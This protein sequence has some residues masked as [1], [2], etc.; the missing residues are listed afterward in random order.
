[1]ER[2]LEQPMQRDVRPGVKHQTKEIDMDDRDQDYGRRRGIIVAGH[3]EKEP[4]HGAHGGT[5]E[6]STYGSGVPRHG[7]QYGAGERF[8]QG[9]R[10]GGSTGSGD[11]RAAYPYQRSFRGSE[12][13]SGQGYYGD[14]RAEGEHRGKGP[15]GYQRADERIEEDVN[16]RLSEDPY[17]D[18]SG[19]EVSVTSSEVTL[20]GQVARRA[21]KRR[22]EDCAESVSGVTNVQNNLRI[23]AS[24]DDDRSATFT[25]A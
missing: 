13:R 24:S 25:Q 9:Y 2:G 15:R 12:E 8:D 19:I 4:R 6:G 7:S 5:D 16:D 10:D 18:A 3:P 11:A 23:R 14:R 1:M 20:S 22:A 21:D 17:L